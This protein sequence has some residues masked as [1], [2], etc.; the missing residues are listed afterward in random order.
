MDTTRRDDLDIRTIANSRI[1]QRKQ[2][3]QRFVLAQSDA[4]KAPD[5]AIGRAGYAKA[6]ARD[7]GVMRPRI[8]FKR[9]EPP[10]Q[11]DEQS[12]IGSSSSPRR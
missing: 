3:N 7:C 5:A 9:V 11:F 4:R 1:L 8:V 6:R 2:G 10:G 12:L